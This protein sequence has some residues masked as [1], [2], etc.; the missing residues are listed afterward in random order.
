MQ[1]LITKVSIPQV[2]QLGAFGKDN[3]ATGSTYELY[4]TVIQVGNDV[5]SGHYVAKLKAA[6]E[7]TY[8]FNDQVVKEISITEMLLGDGYLYFYVKK[9]NRWG[10]YVN[11]PYLTP[12]KQ[13][14]CQNLDPR[15]HPASG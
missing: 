8:E 3:G 1:K 4:G 10:P 15:A 2:L 7:K 6:D 14:F 13:N 9:S 5:R 11:L 12:L